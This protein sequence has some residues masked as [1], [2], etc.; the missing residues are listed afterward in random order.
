MT[1]YR[2]GDGGLTMPPLCLLSKR[3]GTPRT[4][5]KSIIQLRHLHIRASANEIT[6]GRPADI[7]TRLAPPAIV[8]LAVRPDQTKDPLRQERARA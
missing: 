6:D 4:A 8:L 3:K 7:N 1:K 5:Y 2:D